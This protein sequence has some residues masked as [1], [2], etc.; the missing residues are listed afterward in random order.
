[1]FE[2]MWL[3]NCRLFSIHN[4]L[5]LFCADTLEEVKKS[6]GALSVIG[7]SQGVIVAIWSFK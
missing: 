4:F 5:H 2:V 6:P 3:Q 1:M 7:S